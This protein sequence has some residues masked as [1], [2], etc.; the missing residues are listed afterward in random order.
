MRDET[1]GH[2]WIMRIGLGGAGL[3]FGRFS[4]TTEKKVIYLGP[5]TAS[6]SEQHSVTVPDIAG[7]GF[8]VAGVVLLVFSRRSA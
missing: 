2:R 4:Y 6:V 8:L 3:L 1:R 7:I 5:V